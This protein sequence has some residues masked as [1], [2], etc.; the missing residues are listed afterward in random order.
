M[1]WDGSQMEMRRSEVCL[2]LGIG[3][4]FEC[5]HGVRK[6][7][8]EM[9]RLEIIFSGWVIACTVLFSV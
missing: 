3:V 5:F 6:V 7:P 2:V 4:M 8:E 1:R 9:E